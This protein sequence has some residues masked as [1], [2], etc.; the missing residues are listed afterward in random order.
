MRIVA[1]LAVALL[2]G[3]CATDGNDFTARDYAAM[4]CADLELHRQDAQR[5]AKRATYTGA[6]EAAGGTGTAA[7][8]VAGA[9]S[10]WLI[11][12]YAGLWGLGKL[13]GFLDSDV[14]GHT[15]RAET[16]EVIEVV[17]D[18]NGLCDQRV[19]RAGE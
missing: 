13:T 7:A 16:I 10:P 18:M 8:V 12:G 4:T 15:A 3:A 14:A 11:V 2:L 1:P 17:K 9:V 5:D 6:G 19:A